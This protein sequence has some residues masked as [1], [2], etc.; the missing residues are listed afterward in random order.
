MGWIKRMPDEMQPNVDL[1]QN[2]EV[3][4]NP[5]AADVTLCCIFDL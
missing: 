2:A 5:L 3:S 1:A 4:L